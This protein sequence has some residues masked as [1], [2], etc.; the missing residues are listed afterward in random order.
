MA[1]KNK[2]KEIRMREYMMNQ[3]DFSN[4]LDVPVKVY[5][6]WENGKSC[7]TLERALEITKKLNKE[8]KDI[9]YL[10]N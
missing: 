2:L 6:S 4:K 1:I 10:E 3:K 7:P 5:W 8:I 9:W